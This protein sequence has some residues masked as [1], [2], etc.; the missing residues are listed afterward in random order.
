MSAAEKRLDAEAGD[1]RVKRRVGFRT[2]SRP[3]SDGTIAVLKRG[4][5]KIE[6]YGCGQVVNSIIG[7]VL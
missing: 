4:H 6:R 3:E 1:Q 2:S 5:G 7:A